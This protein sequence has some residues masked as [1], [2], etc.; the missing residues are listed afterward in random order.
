MDRKGFRA[1]GAAV[2]GDGGFNDEEV[3]V[4]AIAFGPFL[5]LGIVKMNDARL[6]AHEFMSSLARKGNPST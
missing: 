1:F 6:N 2:K 5:G 4:G 3:L